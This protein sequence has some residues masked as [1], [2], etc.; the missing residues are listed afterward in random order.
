MV[1]EVYPRYL[2]SMLL[3]AIIYSLWGCA[4]TIQ[5]TEFTG[6]FNLSTF[7]KENIMGDEAHQVDFQIL[8]PDDAPVS[9]GLLRLEWVDNGG[10]MSFQTDGQGRV[11]MHFEEDFLEWD[12]IAS[13]ETKPMDQDLIQSDEYETSTQPLTNGTILVS[14]R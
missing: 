9:F 6:S 13:A 14:W 10:R 2:S 7:L 5:Q 1:R 4:P 3:G 12:V 8:G 11:T